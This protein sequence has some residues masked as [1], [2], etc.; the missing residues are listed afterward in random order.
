MPDNRLPQIKFGD[1]VLEITDHHH[2]QPVSADLY[3]E[4]RLY[5]NTVCLSFAHIVMDGDGRAEARISARVRLTLGGAMDLR[6]AL[7]NLLQQ[8]MPGKEKAN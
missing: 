1:S 5:N 6:K 4:A 3:T 8:E 7:D 2:I